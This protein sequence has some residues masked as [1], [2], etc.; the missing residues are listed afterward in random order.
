MRYDALRLSR[1]TTPIATYLYQYFIYV[2]ILI[3]EVPKDGGVRKPIFMVRTASTRHCTQYIDQETTDQEAGY[4]RLR[5]R[6]TGL[7]AAEGCVFQVRV[8]RRHALLIAL[9]TAM[10]RVM[11]TSIGK[12]L[13]GLIGSGK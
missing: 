4:L 10:C 3:I 7:A 5:V 11:S 8:V 12:M 6:N 1:E 13:C 9:H 2:S